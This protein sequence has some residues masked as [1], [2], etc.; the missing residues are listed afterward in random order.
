MSGQVMRRREPAHPSPQLPWARILRLLALTYKTGNWRV[1]VLRKRGADPFLVLVSTIISQRTRDEVTE[2]VTL[3]LLSRLPTPLAVSRSPVSR[4]KALIREAGLTKTKAFALKRI[5]RSLVDKFGGRVPTLESELL[6][7]PM[8]GPK[9]AHAVLVFAHRRPGLPVD[10]HILRVA[11]RLGAVHAGTIPG[12]QFELA[13]S[14]PERY[15]KF[16]NP[17]LVQHGQNICRA[18]RPRCGVCPIRV[19]CLR[20]GVGHEKG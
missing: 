14:V 19:M 12:A 20:I 15:W 3:R 9:T 2:R 16:L 13:Q 4:V 1:P 8:V 17:V 18:T 6:S 10:T 11:R 7:L 5:S